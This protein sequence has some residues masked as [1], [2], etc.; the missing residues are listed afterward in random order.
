MSNLELDR[1]GWLIETAQFILD[2]ILLPVSP[3][4]AAPR[5]RLS[6]GNPTGRNSKALACCY[7]REA[8]ADAHNEIFV[9]PSMDDSLEILSALVH[10]LIHAIDNC[11]SGH[12]GFFAITARRVGL[13][14]KLTQTHASTDLKA[15]L[16]GYIDLLGDIP[17]AKL[18]MSKARKKGGTRML[19]CQCEECGF[20]YRTSSKWLTDMHNTTCNYCG[21]DRMLFN[22]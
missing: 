16:Q 13:E 8:S 11:E 9:T 5:V 2:D 18:D 10:E 12:R 6:I 20:T 19:K 7:K 15:I 1:E 21:C 22:V 17:H 14:G 4:H 3:D